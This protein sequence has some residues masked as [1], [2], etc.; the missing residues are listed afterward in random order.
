M[1]VGIIPARSGSK[2]VP[3][4][5]TKSLGG[6]PLIAYSIMAAKQSKSI[7][8]VIVSTDS[9]EIADI[10]KMYGA[11]VPFLRPAELSLD[12]STDME[13]IAHFLEWHKKKE[14]ILPELLVHLRPT[15]P[16][17]EPALIDAAVQAIK[18]NK[19]ATSL[20]SAHEMAES[21]RK[22]FEIDNGF[23]VGLFPNDT[24]L[25]YYNLPR[26]SFPPAYHPNG[27]V[28]VLKPDFIM[29]NDSLHGPKILAFITPF[30]VEVDQFEDFEYLQFIIE[31]KGH[32][33]YEILKSSYE[34]RESP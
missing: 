2:K 4:K 8:R 3:K 13:F 29:G 32:R 9:R 19:A 27:Y 12:T 20:R 28:D 22:A 14:G 33:L 30:S 26:Q 24:R 23:L 10:A 18:G 31:K 15:T 1:I 16:L 34:M 25:E 11:E 21:P 7:D 5:N 6:Y 17:R